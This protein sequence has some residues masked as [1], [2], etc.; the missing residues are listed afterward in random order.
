MTQTPTT[1]GQIQLRL[2][3]AIIAISAGI[4]GLT[5]AILLIKDALA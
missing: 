4:A 2:L 3:A 5:I 1:T